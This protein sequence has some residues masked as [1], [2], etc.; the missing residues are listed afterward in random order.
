MASGQ[1]YISVVMRSDRSHGKVP[2]YRDPGKCDHGVSMCP[3]WTCIESWSM[4]YQVLLPS[5]VA[6]R[7]LAAELNIDPV[8]FATSEHSGLEMWHQKDFSLG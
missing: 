6:G 8:K 7:E 3:S 4:D 2:Y 1:S 5:T